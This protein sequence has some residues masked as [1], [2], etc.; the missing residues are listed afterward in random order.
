MNLDSMKTKELTNNV[1]TLRK[2]GNKKYERAEV[3]IFL[4]SESTDTA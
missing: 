4:S 2:V 1:A 3:L